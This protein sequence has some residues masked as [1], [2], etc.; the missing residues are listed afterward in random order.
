[1]PHCPFSCLATGAAKK[2]VCLAIAI[3][4]QNYFDLQGLHLSYRDIFML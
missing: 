2:I 1:M 4:V 3:M